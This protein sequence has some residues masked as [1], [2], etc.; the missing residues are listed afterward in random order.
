MWHKLTDANLCIYYH[1]FCITQGHVHSITT[2]CSK[3][4]YTIIFV[5]KKCMK[6][7]W[8]YRIHLL[9]CWTT[10]Q[11]QKLQCHIKK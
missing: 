2:F 1:N 10:L 11:V 9:R 7:T 6:R 5:Y 4:C 8:Q 3:T